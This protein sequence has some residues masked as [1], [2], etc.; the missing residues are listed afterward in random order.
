MKQTR[1]FVRLSFILLAVSFLGLIVSL[2]TVWSWMFPC[3]LW[4]H[5]AV[6]IVFGLA[7][8]QVGK[9]TVSNQSNRA[10]SI[11]GRSAALKSFPLWL[12]GLGVAAVIAAVPLWS[13]AK[14]D[15]GKT[16]AGEMIT[17]RSWYVKEDRYSLVMNRGPAKE[18]S[19][20][21][22]EELTRGTYEVFA[23]RWV[24]FSFA[25]LFMWY[26]LLRACSKNQ[27]AG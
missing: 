25:S 22:Y 12:V 2:T 5:V 7:V 24:V 9:R 8:L 14:F 6:M 21:E 17:R 10:R 15:F 11:A 4:N 20:A 16:E 3:L 26:H 18:I 23:R 19:K 13:P 1:V 27:D